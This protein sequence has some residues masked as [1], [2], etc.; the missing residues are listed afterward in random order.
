[1]LELYNR[2]DIFGCPHTT[3]NDPMSVFLA[4]P[5]RDLT[6]FVLSFKFGAKKGKGDLREARIVDDVLVE[7]LSVTFASQRTAFSLLHS[8]LSAPPLPPVLS[9]IGEEACRTI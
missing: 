2:L 4:G 6:E 1:M 3:T 5:G 9:H 7:S 8:S